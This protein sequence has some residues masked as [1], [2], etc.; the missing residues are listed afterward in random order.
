V[1]NLQDS[2]SESWQFT[3]F[4][5]LQGVVRRV[6]N[7]QEVI[8]LLH[9]LGERGKRIFRKLLP[10]LPKSALVIA[11]NAPFPMPRQKV[12]RL[13]Y[14]HTWYFYNKFENNYFI[15][16]DLA[17]FWLRDLLKIENPQSLPVTIIGFS[18]GGYLAPL[19]GKEIKET[20]LIIGL[21]CEFRTTLIHERPLFPMI[22]IHGEKDQVVTAKSAM[23][24]IEKLKSLDIKVEWHLVPEAGHEITF[25]MGQIVG[26]ILEQ[27]GKSSL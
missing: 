14:G 19:V 3:S 8:L 11:P 25:G 6:D 15:N 20:K 10:Y 7:P 13:D 5:H 26:K 9:G 18:Q 4:A 24:E 2:T 1:K 16:Q 21:A 17:K 12:E 23:D 27:Y 22:A